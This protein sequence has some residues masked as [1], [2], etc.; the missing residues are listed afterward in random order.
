MRIEPT[1]DNSNKKD[2]VFARRRSPLPIAII[3]ANALL[4]GA[5]LALLLVSQ[6]LR[7]QYDI[8][9]DNESMDAASTL[10]DIIDD[11]IAVYMLCGSLLLFSFAG[12][13]ALWI[14]R[15]SQSRFLRYGALLLVLLVIMLIAVVFLLGVTGSASVPLP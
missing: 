2:D 6:L 13:V 4:I 14:W 15:K 8:Y 10:L 5:C 7:S 3:A 1:A 9:I 12:S 11:F